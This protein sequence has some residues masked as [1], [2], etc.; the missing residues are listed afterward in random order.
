MLSFTVSFESFSD[1]Y[2]TFREVFLEDEYHFVAKNNHPLIIDCGG[3]IGLSVLYFKY[4]YPKA[5]VFVFE[6]LPENAEIL[7]R[8]IKNNS[9]ENVVI[10][11][12]AVGESFGTIQICGDRRA[13]T[14]SEG[15]KSAHTKSDMSACVD[16]EV[17]PLSTFIDKEVDFLKMDIE[18]AEGQVLQELA[19]T[20]ALE[21]L[22]HVIL[23]YHAF[24]GG[25]NK[26]SDIISAFEGANFSISF[27]SNVTRAI[28]MNARSFS[29]IMIV[30]KKRS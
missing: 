29:H 23:E 5:K 17:V 12:K 27:I 11:K 13:A 24:E 16:V 9:L 21:K 10:I 6:A 22:Q 3:N 18:G 4:L 8:N 15:M 30:A 2:W 19:K 25:E 7:E 14:I 26:L 28:D 1:F 20:D